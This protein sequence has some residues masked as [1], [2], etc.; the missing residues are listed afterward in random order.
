M[1]SLPTE[2]LEMIVES[3]HL[4]D[5]KSLRSTCKAF[6]DITI[7]RIFEEIYTSSFN[8]HLDRFVAISQQAHFARH[9]KVLHVLPDFTSP[10]IQEV[11]DLARYYMLKRDRKDLPKRPTGFELSTAWI[12]LKDLR[13]NQICWDNDIRTERNNKNNIAFNTAIS[14]LDNLTH[15]DNRAK[16]MWLAKRSPRL[17]PKI[18]STL[19]G[20]DNWMECINRWPGDHES[21]N[22]P[23]DDVISERQTHMLLHAIAY[24]SINNSSAK[25]IT[26][27]NLQNHSETPLTHQQKI[28]G[29][30]YF[31]TP[32]MAGM[33]G[34]V[35]LNLELRYCEARDAL[36]DE[37]DIVMTSVRLAT[38]LQALFERTR[39]LKSLK[40]GLMERCPIDTVD[41]YRFDT[42]GHIKEDALHFPELESLTLTGMFTESGILRL[43]LPNASTLRKLHLVECTI[44]PGLGSWTTVFRELKPPTFSL[45]DIYFS[46]LVVFSNIRVEASSD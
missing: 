2:L 28:P 18:R 15:I 4:G 19:I 44:L 41:T 8:I 36:G 26:S 13:S 37:D 10:H 33:D 12:E 42:L 6:L 17:L 45:Q 24:R 9:V 39:G 29:S 25:P 40:L 11:H 1:Q 30:D 3:C 46:E 5:L 38:Y 22:P 16:P 20:P 31:V 21:W 23:T 43:L 32:T 34:L 7:P 14:R 35:E 27:L